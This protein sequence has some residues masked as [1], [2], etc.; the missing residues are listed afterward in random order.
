MNPSP[1]ISHRPADVAD[2]EDVRDDD[3]GD[4]NHPETDKDD[5]D[6]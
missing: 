3:D 5:D 1:H 6:E 2:D 4:W